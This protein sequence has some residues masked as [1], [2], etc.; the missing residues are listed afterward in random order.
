MILGHQLF[1]QKHKADASPERHR[2]ILFRCLIQMHIRPEA[3]KQH[4]EDVDEGL[5]ARKTVRIVESMPDK[6]QDIDGK[7]C[8]KDEQKPTVHSFFLHGDLFA[9]QIQQE[10]EKHRDAAVNIRPVIQTDLRLHISDV[11]GDH[12]KDREVG[13]PRFREVKIT[14]R[15][16]LK[17]V[18]LREQ[19]SS[20]QPAGKQGINSKSHAALH[21]FSHRSRLL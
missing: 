18:D 16:A 2:H 20:R 17:R 1:R 15:R 12:I 9:R 11:A 8:E 13:T 3:D 4:Q 19:H 7:T 5:T 21:I 14:G 10:E 6:I